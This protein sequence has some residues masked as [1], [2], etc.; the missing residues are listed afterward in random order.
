MQSDA[1]VTVCVFGQ[2]RNTWG[3]V[4]IQYQPR[5]MQLYLAQDTFRWCNGTLDNHYHDNHG[6][7]WKYRSIEITMEWSWQ[8]NDF[9]MGRLK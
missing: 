2:R 6:F 8:W 7:F 9:L 3:N 4:Y 1:R 5:D